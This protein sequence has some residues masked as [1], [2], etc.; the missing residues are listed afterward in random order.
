M[1]TSAKGRALI[2]SFEG[3]CLHVYYDI[4]GNP[5]IG[6][7][8]KL[9]PG[10]SYPNGITEPKA[11]QLLDSDLVRTEDGVNSLVRVPLTQGQFDALVDF[12]YN[13]G[14]G[15]LAESTLLRLLNQGNY[16]GAADQFTRWDYA[17]DEVSP[18][19]LR[20]REAEREMFLG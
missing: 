18:G 20:R 3:L 2:E 14:I 9:L 5:T 11:D 10:E 8:H 12:A 15:S 16:A 17:G 19:L 4:D 7:G 13:L 1:Q 6:Y